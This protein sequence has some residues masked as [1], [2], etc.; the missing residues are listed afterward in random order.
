MQNKFNKL[1]TLVEQVIITLIQE[2]RYS[3]QLIKSIDTL[4]IKMN[5]LPEQLDC[6]ISSLQLVD[7]YLNG[8][9]EKE[10]LD[11]ETCLSITI[12]FSQVSILACNGIWSIECDKCLLP[13]RD[14]FYAEDESVWVYSLIIEIYSTGFML[15][16]HYI[17]MD[18]ISSQSSELE[19]EVTA[20]ASQFTQHETD[21]IHHFRYELSGLETWINEGH[22]FYLEIPFL[23]SRLSDVL[24]IP[25]SKLNKSVNSLRLVNNRV[26]ASG[27]NFL[28]DQEY[29][30]EISFLA[31]TVYIGEVVIKAVK[32]EWRISAEKFQ[33]GSIRKYRWVMKIF[34]SK[35]R[36]LEDFL[37]NMRSSLR[38]YTY[39]QFRADSLVKY[40]I[41]AD[42]EQDDTIWRD[43]TPYPKTRVWKKV[44]EHRS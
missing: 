21:E 3:F 38:K 37:F 28:C 41:R 2:N 18:N 34:N 19:R 24:S 44:L 15:H 5:V 30:D 23:I 17:V 16:P 26:H 33:L 27:E 6:S 14:D 9:K 43:T 32:G 39:E 4:S 40:Y 13:G 1:F 7:N 31:L 25:K 20:H 12:Y 22:N 36:E 35:D 10:K 42:R 8:L 29:F 11:I